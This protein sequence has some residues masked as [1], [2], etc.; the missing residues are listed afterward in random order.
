MMPATAMPDDSILVRK[1]VA[2][3]NP[4]GTKYDVKP[5]FRV[6]EDALRRSTL[7][8]TGPVNHVADRSH[9]TGYSGMPEAL[10]AKIDEISCEITYKNIN[11]VDARSSTVAILEMLTMYNWDVKI[12]LAIAALALTYGEF[13]LLV[14]IHDTYQHAKSKEI[15]KQLPSFTENVDMLK[16]KPTYDTLKDVVKVILEVT[17]CIIKFHD[18]ETQ[19]IPQDI[20]GHGNAYN[21]VPVACYWTVRSIVSCAAQITSLNDNEYVNTSN[22]HPWSVEMISESSKD[23]NL[24]DI[25]NIQ[26]TVSGRS[27]P[28]ILGSYPHWLPSSKT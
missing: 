15:L 20:Q 24:N 14:H 9:H 23:H 22:N 27:H 25:I 11:C 13:W 10:S 2:E 8:S 6:V 1:A 26:N 12:V 28:P 21:Y 16:Q 4:D 18:L 5:I 17:S 7:S 3:H 19:Y